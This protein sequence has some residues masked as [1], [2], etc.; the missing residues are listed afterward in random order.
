ML[1]DDG[2]EVTVTLTRTHARALGLEEG[3][4]VWLSPAGGAH[5]VPTMRAV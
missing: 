3:Q 5:M 1:T 4:T 2:E